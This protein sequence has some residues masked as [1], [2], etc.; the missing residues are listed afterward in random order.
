ME[1]VSR[2]VPLLVTALA[3]GLIVVSLWLMQTSPSARAEREREGSIDGDT[4]DAEAAPGRALAAVTVDSMVASE[5]SARI[6]AVV[7][8]VL[9]PLRSVVVGAEV[10]GKVVDVAAEE[11][12]LIEKDAL[13]VQLDP[14]L[15]EA[16]RDHAVASLALAQASLRQSI[17]ELQRQR[18]LAKRGI[19]SEVDLERAETEERTATA[20]VAETQAQKLEVDTRLEKTRITAPFAAVVNSLDLEPG[21]YLSPGSP[22]AELIDISEIELEVGVGDRQITALERGSTVRITVD[23][24]P[25]ESFQGVIH[26]LGRAPDAGTGRYPVPIRIPN[27]DGRLL[28]GMLATA[29]FE[30][31]DTQPVIRIPRSAVLREFEIDY[32][33]V[34]GPAPNDPATSIV[35]RRSIRARPVPF[36]P[37]LIEVESGLAAGERIALTGLKNLLDGAMA[38]ARQRG[39]AQ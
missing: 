31:G 38:K 21:A 24:L 33:F 1:K 7:S 15:I 28:P 20:R 10:P 2:S 9:A 14:A 8:G 30:L 25:G 6:E 12:Q 29:H 17:A 27:K 37:D 19:A 11:H 39:D 22:V 4:A 36:R 5:A 35:A 13:L 3:A 23:I 26:H 32:V 16:S 18:D 34:L